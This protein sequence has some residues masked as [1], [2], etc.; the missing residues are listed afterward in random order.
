MM[1]DDA[2]AGGRRCRM[3]GADAGGCRL[4]VAVAGFRFPVAGGKCGCRLLVAG[5]Q[6]MYIMKRTGHHTLHG[7]LP[8]YNK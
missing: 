1:P 5:R 4:P 7:R 2:G 6:K 3:P 8:F